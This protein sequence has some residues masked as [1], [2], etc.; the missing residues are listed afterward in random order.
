MDEKKEVGEDFIGDYGEVLSEEEET[1]ERFKFPLKILLN[2]K[3]AENYKLLDVVADDCYIRK[4]LPEN[5]KYSSLEWKGKH[6]YIH[7]LDE[8]PM[9]IKNN[10]FDIVMCIETLEHT[11]Y[12]SRVIEELLRISKKNAIFILSMPNEYNFWCR[13][14]FLL[15]RKTKVQKPFKVIEEHGHIQLPR[16]KDIIDLFSQ[17][18]DIKKIHY[19]WYSRTSDVSTGFKNKVFNIFDDIIRFL[20]RVK[21]ALFARNVTILGYKKGN[22]L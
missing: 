19:T 21:P 7:N 1:I 9:P 22:D 11:L 3:G 2:L 12:P 17:Y 4:F 14:N 13:I 20:S 5:I 10:E 15:N 18:L 8:F 16:T 6:D